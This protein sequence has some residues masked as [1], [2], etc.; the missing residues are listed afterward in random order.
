MKRGVAL[1]LAALAGPVAPAAL[2]PHHPRVEDAQL[3]VPTPPTAV[4]EPWRAA[5]PLAQAQARAERSPGP[6]S[7]APPFDAL[8]RRTALVADVD[9]ALLHAIIDTE[10]GYDPTAVSERGAIGLMQILPRTGQRFGVRR[11]ED[12]AENLRAGAAYV[13]WL[14]SRFDGDL[15][16]VLAAYN[17]GEGAVLRHGRQVPPFAETRR[18]V[19]RV[20]DAY[21]RLQDSGA[22]GEAV[23]PSSQKRVDAVGSAAPFVAVVPSD[24]MESSDPYDSVANVGAAGKAAAG[25]PSGAARPLPAGAQTASPVPAAR[26][27]G[28]DA[29]GAWRLLRDLGVLVTRSPSAEAERK[30]RRDRPAVMY[31]RPVGATAQSAGRGG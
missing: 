26:T 20:M 5:T 2:L 10:S 16:L 9:A 21:S 11:L 7:A 25:K 13:R 8:V 1:V 14:L 23:A 3:A 4:A 29:S 19:Q 28:A 15:R 6:A 24:S 17:A 30:R 12:P 31:E 27:D 18:F 22:S